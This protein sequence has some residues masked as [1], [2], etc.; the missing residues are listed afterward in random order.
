MSDYSIL[1]RQCPDRLIDPPEYPEPDDVAC[2]VCGGQFDEYIWYVD[3]EGVC[4]KC[5]QT[6]LDE[7]FAL[8]EF[9]DKFGYRYMRVE[10]V[11]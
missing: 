1:S 8:W 9:A 7:Q 4:D 6:E 3:G 10:D 2:P 11:L 5:F